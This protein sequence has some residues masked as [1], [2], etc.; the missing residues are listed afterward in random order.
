[1]SPVQIPPTPPNGLNGHVQP[2][3]APVSSIN[4]LSFSTRALHIGSEPSLSASNGVV[5]ELSLSTTYQQSKVGQHRGY[6]Y[7]RS[8]NPTRRALERQLASLEGNADRLLEENLVAE[9]LNEGW[10]AGSAAVAFASGS[11]AT[12]TVISGLASRGG[13]IV[14]VGDV[15]GGTSRYMLKVAQELQGTTTSFVDLSYQLDQA[16]QVLKGETEEQKREQDERDD[17]ELSERLEGAIR[18]DTKVIWVETPTN[19]M[20]SLVPIALIA[21]VAKKH[22]IPLVVDNTFSNPYYQNPLTLGASVVVHSATKYLGGHSDV[23]GGVIVTPIPSL[24]SRF[25]FLQNANGNVPSPFDCWLLIRSLKTLT[26]RSRE[27]GLNA[28]RVAR[29]LQEVGV[30]AGLVRDVRYPGLKRAIESKGERRERELAWEQLSAEAKKWIVKQGFSAESE[31]G[32]PSGGMVSFHILSEE[33]GSQTNSAAAERF[34]EG[35]EL[36]A[37]A[38]SLGGVESL[39]ELPLKMTHGGVAPER[40]AQLGINGELIRLSVG[41]EDGDDLVAD[42]ERSLRAAIEL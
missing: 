32:F 9:G 38:E 34:L 7:S 22:G 30:P 28:L 37:L 13:H 39:A 33:E 29:W 6:E 24:L 21:R 2:L 12:A 17:E 3:T 16:R 19:P 23:L 10:E 36:F 35:L 5:P 41:I 4:S 31:G 14:S 8:D 42:V 27:H 40:R 20:L 18:E 26:I 11:A 15:Y 25:R 1:M